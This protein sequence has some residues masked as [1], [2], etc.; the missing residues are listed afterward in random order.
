MSSVGFTFNSDTPP[1][2]ENCDISLSQLQE[3]SDHYTKGTYFLIKGKLEKSI[4]QF[5][6]C[7]NIDSTYIDAYYNRAVALF[8]L[9]NFEGA[10]KDWEKLYEFGQ[11]EGERLYIQNCKK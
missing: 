2:L 6:D 9:N 7:I 10:C 8:K 5:T 3:A 1:C 11:K 4:I